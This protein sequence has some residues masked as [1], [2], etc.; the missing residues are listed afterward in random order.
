MLCVC[1]CVRKGEGGFSD[2]EQSYFGDSDYVEREK[3]RETGRGVCDG[4]IFFFSF[5]PVFC[6]HVLQLLPD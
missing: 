5:L 6:S 1:V 3:N 2:V 4:L